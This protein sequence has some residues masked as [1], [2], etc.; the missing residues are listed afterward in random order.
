MHFGLAIFP[1]E[2]SIQPAELATA[3]EERG[4]ESIWVAEHTHIPASRQSPWP[5]GA[6]LPQEYYDLYDP[7]TALTTMAA[8]TT[9]LKIGTGVCLV[10]Q[11]DPIYLAK[12]VA[13]L[14]RVSNGRFLF[15]IG[16]G[17]NVEELENHAQPFRR[18]WK[19]VRETIEAMQAIWTQEQ[20]EYHGE[21]VDFDPIFSN[22]KPVQQPHPPIHVGGE[23]PY[24]IR[25]TVRYGNGWIPITG[26]S[27]MP[28]AEHVLALRQAAEEAG[29]DPDALEVTAYGVPGQEELIHSY[30]D[31][32]VHRVVF[33]LQ[34]MDRDNALGAMDHYAAVAAAVRS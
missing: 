20:A 18:R 10:A 24:G 17:W 13:T 14:D 25:R 26:R 31:A 3:A 2:Y 23:P 9:T 28:M 4:F 7:F 22:P 30:I 8:V 21:F 27:N 33:F 15:G 29:R 1:T 19:V 6:D 5:G 34:A 16:G 12:Q 11:H 32:G